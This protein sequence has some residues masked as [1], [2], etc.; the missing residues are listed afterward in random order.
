MA[1]QTVPP[2][3]LPKGWPRRVHSVAVH[4]IALAQFA[5]THSPAQPQP[6][7]PNERSRSGMVTGLSGGS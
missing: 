3:P 4:A 5:L 7:S 2:L 1:R 6:R